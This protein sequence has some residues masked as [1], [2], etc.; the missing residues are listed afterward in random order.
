[1]QGRTKLQRITAIHNFNE[2]M[3]GVLLG[4][5]NISFCVVTLACVCDDVLV[6]LYEEMQQHEDACN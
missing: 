3:L 1:M 5:T 4:Y 2:L 6:A